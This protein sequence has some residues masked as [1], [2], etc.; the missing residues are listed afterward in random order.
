MAEKDMKPI[1][2]TIVVAIALSGCR[3]SQSVEPITLDTFRDTEIYARLKNEPVPL[4]TETP[5][6]N[7]EKQRE[8]YNEGFRSGWDWAISGALLHGTFATPT[9]LPEETHTAWSAGWKLGTKMGSGR[10][11]TER[12]KLCKEGGQ[13]GHPD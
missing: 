6:W 2:A 4:P 3:N 13:S 7:D 1:L 11:M 5:F 10:W 12:D 9:D 8:S